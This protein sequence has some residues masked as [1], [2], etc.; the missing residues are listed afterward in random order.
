VVLMLN[1]PPVF[2]F[3]SAT[4]V[5]WIGSWVD[6]IP[7]KLVWFFQEMQVPRRLR[8]SLSGSFL[9]TLDEICRKMQKITD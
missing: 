9:K 2:P 8:K 5:N 4:L 6:M 1:V 7:R 3:S